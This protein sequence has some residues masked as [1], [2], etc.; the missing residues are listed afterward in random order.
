MGTIMWLFDSLWV[1]FQ[2]ALSISNVIK[3][4]KNQ[5]Q[6]YNKGL[7]LGFNI[8]EKKYLQH[9]NNKIVISLIFV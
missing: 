1:Q 8:F 9:L 7:I 4:H 5:N 2:M 3:L 6:L